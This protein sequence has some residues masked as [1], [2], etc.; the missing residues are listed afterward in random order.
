MSALRWDNRTADEVARDD[1]L[2]AMADCWE[3]PKSADQ[4]LDEIEEEL[5]AIPCFIYEATGMCRQ[6]L[7][8]QLVTG[9]R[10]NDAQLVADALS[11]MVSEYADKSL[12]GEE[13]RGEGDEAYDQLDDAEKT[14]ANWK[15]YQAAED[16]G[17][18]E[19][20]DKAEAAANAAAWDSAA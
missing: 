17:R 6:E 13:G 9:Y 10:T 15:R 20:A 7:V 2:D 3:A 12:Y 4:R 11:D 19:S 1:R 16:E 14:L 18:K 5:K 8:D